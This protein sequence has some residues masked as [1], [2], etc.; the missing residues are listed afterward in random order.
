MRFAGLDINFY[1]FGISPPFFDPSRPL[2]RDDGAAADV[3][4][5]ESNER[6]IDR[7]VALVFGDVPDCWHQLL[8]FA[9]ASLLYHKEWLKAHV[10][11]EN[12]F[13]PSEPCL[14]INSL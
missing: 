11:P 3:E 14:Y 2:L 13:R 5:A 12:R 8:R 6:A 7:A 4:D 1:K 9:L 10:Q